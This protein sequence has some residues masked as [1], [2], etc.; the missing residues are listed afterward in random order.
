[1]SCKNAQSCMANRDH[2]LSESKDDAGDSKM[3]NLFHAMPKVLLVRTAYLVETYLV[4]VA[5]VYDATSVALAAVVVLLVHSILI[6][7]FD[8]ID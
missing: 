5:H 3:V 2:N 8:L 4:C 7:L 1:M 6:D